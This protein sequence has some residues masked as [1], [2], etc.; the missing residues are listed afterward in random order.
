MLYTKP[1]FNLKETKWECYSTCEHNRI[2]NTNVNSMDHGIK[3]R[4][5]LDAM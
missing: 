5:R 3:C 2:S 1:N 4:N